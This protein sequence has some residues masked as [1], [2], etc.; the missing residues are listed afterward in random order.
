MLREN[1]NQ[2]APALSELDSQPERKPVVSETLS[3]EP[4]LDS[5]QAAA[6]I[7]IHPKTLQKFA[8][9]GQ[10]QGIH[11]GKLWRFRLSALEAWLERQTGT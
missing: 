11:V 6:M 5:D 2:S 7:Q 3:F 8:R 4:L 9:Q 1:F 10:I